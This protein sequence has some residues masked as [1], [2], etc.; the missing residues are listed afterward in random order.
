[1]RPRSEGPSTQRAFRWEYRSKVGDRDMD[2]AQ[3]GSEGWELIGVIPSPA[4][5]AVFY[6][7]RRKF[8]T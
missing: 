5:Q 1:M 4:D 8:G 6:F 2:L 7:K 3:F